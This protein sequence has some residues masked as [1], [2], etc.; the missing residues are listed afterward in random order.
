MTPIEQTPDP[1]HSS[2]AGADA[3]MDLTGKLLIAMPGMGNPRFEHSVIYVCAHSEEG[4]MGLIVNKPS[5]D[6]KLRELLEQLEVQVDAGLP[7]MPVHFGGPVEHARGFVLH[8]P[9]FTSAAHS[10]EVDER[11]RMTG[12]LDILEAIGRGLG[13]ERAILALGYAGWGEGQLEDEIAQN[14]WLTC[15][16]TPELVFGEADDSKWEAALGTLGVSA[17]TLSSEAGHA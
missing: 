14:A 5:P 17:L 4:A 12:T 9:D 13:P 16:A 6:I 10:L 3:A 7:R 11:F 8:S 15:D 2:T 1:E